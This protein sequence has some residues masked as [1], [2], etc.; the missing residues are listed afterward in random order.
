MA[1]VEITKDKITCYTPPSESSWANKTRADALSWLNQNGLP[2]GREEYWK[3][4]NP[5]CFNSDL[6]C[7]IGASFSYETSITVPPVNSIEKCRPL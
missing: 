2:D 3:Y 6:I 1:K 4:T 5:T 7:S